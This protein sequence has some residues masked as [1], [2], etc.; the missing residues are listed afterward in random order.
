ME[1]LAS[2]YIDNELDLTEKGWFIDRINQDQ[3]F[4]M[5]TRDLLHQEKMLRRA[6]DT[7]MIPDRPPKAVSTSDWLI[8]LFKPI[9]YASGGFALAGLLLLVFAANSPSPVNTNRFVLYEPDAS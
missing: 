3:S 2:L 1:Y 8:R 9:I 5:E 4:Y 6:P 7:S